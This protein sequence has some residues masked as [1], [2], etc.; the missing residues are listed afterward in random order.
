ME[1]TL[2]EIYY[3]KWVKIRYEWKL[4]WQGKWNTFSIIDFFDWG[5]FYITLWDSAKLYQSEKEMMK[6]MYWKSIQ[7]L[8]DK[9]QAKID[10]WKD[11]EGKIKEKIE[12]IAKDYWEWM[13]L[14]A[15]LSKAV[16]VDIA[17][18]ISMKLQEKVREYLT[19]I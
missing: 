9:Q 16:W 10:E 18:A 14:S 5:N 13:V 7:D 4:V 11:M 6:D 19:K 17:N 12:K 1:L 2:Y 15:L 8:I 3:Y